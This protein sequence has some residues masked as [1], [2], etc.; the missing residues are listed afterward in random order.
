MRLIGSNPASSVSIAMATYN[1][2]AH[3]EEQFD[4]LFRQTRLPDEVIVFDDASSDQ[5]TL[6]LRQ[7]AARA[8]FAMHVLEGTHNCGV[9]AAFQ[10]ALERCSG[11]T[12]FFCDQDDI[13]LPG[14][15]EVCLNALNAASGA[16]FVF[17]DATQFSTDD[18][19]AMPSLWELAR[20][21]ARRRSAFRRDPLAAML[22]GGNF[23]YGMA[24]AFRRQVLRPFQFIDCD[25]VGMTHDTWFAMHASAL[26]AY[27]VALPERLVRYRRHKSQTSV[28]LGAGGPDAASRL[29][30]S[31]SRAT[32]LISALGNV[33]RNI[34]REASHLGLDVTKSIVYLDRKIAFLEYR[35]YLR[36]ERSLIGALRGVANLDYWRLASGPASVLRDYR[37]IW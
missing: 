1:G 15:I 5:T 28:V 3:L 20:F 10:S 35:E 19:G 7:I 23:V 24:S 34:Q 2:A 36:R 32:A 14:K 30:K 21:S 33:R 16:S 13:W 29:R 22:T 26:G 18:R 37:G 25:P 31:Q 27:G 17:C 4:S 6:L 8:P 11:E 12:V 9:N